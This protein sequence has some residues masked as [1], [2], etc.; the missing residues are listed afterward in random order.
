[1]NLQVKHRIRKVLTYTV[2]GTIFLLITSFLVLQIPAVQEYLIKRYLGGFSEVTGFKT[3]IGSFQL[4]WFD[5]LELKN[6]NVYDPEK[7]RMI[8]A[9]TIIVNFELSQLFKQR[10][11]NIDGVFVEG[12]H[13]FITKLQESDTSKT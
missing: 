4:L 13:V 9:E 1:M 8:G 12:S 6:V 7:N 2:T 11:V 3:T 10:D 5:R